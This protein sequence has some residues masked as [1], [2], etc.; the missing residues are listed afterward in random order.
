MRTNSVFTPVWFPKADIWFDPPENDI[1]VF[2]VPTA[3]LFEIVGLKQSIIHSQI[4]KCLIA[5][6]PP[7]RQLHIHRDTNEWGQPNIPWSIIWTPNDHDDIAVQVFEPN[8][9]TKYGEMPAPSGFTMPCIIEGTA[10]VV[11]QWSM[12]N[13]AAFF[14]AGTV[15][16]TAANIGS[17]PQVI[18]SIRRAHGIGYQRVLDSVIT[19]NT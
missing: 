9:D 10:P 17:T 6:I 15:W 5:C 12:S 16:H 14:D 1:S 3:Q 11:D 13:G 8:A 18:V 4:Y 7:G 2:F 19:T